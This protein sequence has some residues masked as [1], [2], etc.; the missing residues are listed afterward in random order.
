[1]L[2]DRITAA[3][4][5]ILHRRI[6]EREEQAYGARAADIAVEL[7]VH[8]ERGHDYRRAAQ[9]LQY[10]A[11]NAQQKSAYQ[12][13]ISLAT[14]GLQLLTD[15]PDTPKRAR[16]ELALQLALG[17]AL[18]TVKGYTAP[19]VE[20]ALTQARA[21]SQKL[22]ENPKLFPVLGRLFV[23]YVNRPQVQ[24]AYELAEKMIRLAQRAQNPLLFPFA[25]A[26]LG[27]AL[28]LLGELASARTHMEQAS[29]LYDPQQFPRFTGNRSDL[30]VD[31]LSYRAHILWFLG[32]PDQA[33]KLTQEAIALAKGLSHPFSLA[34]AL[35]FASL[36]YLYRRDAPI[37]R[38]R[39]EAVMTLATEQGFPY[40]LA[41]G[42]GVRDCAFAEQGQVKERI[43]RMRRNK[44]TLPPSLLAE[45]CGKVGQIEEGLALVAKALAS[46]DKTGLRMNEADLYRGKGEL[47]LQQ[48][49]AQGSKLLTPE[50]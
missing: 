12:E 13:A 15:L 28:F 48:F 46:V 43:A 10:A 6:G 1:V 29:A 50:P 37:A 3:R 11:E 19:E 20:N 33:L 27:G 21:I 36:F 34:F 44:L 22:G 17:D 2:Y 39:A 47:T 16:Q 35:G 18:G 38:E 25:H 5:A 31:C 42:M 7:A 24:T 32:Y 26:A 14:R 30:R 40:W 45:V 9:Y 41:F 49:K 23:F 8:F 4:K